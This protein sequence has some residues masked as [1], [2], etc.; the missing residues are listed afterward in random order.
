MAALPGFEVL[1]W[2]GVFAPAGTPPAII[3]R[4]NSEIGKIVNSP[5]MR[6]IWVDKGVETVTGSPADLGNKL[7]ADYIRVGDLLKKLKVTK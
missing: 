7:N 3:A 4:L 2:E 6:K 5:A 1:S